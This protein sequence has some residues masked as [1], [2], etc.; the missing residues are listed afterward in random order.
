MNRR[1][2]PRIALTLLCLTLLPAVASA[3][4][5]R[6][7]SGSLAP[8]KQEKQ[9]NLEFDFTSMKVGS[10]PKN[11]V[12][13]AEFIARL[14]QNKPG[15]GDAWRREWVGSVP[16]YE[17]KFKELLNH[18]LES[19][20]RSLTFGAFKD[21][22][23]TLVLKTTTLVLGT[24]GFM[25]SSPFLSAD[26]IFVETAHRTNVSAVVVLEKMPGAGAFA[27]YMS[28]AFAKAGKDL[29]NLLRSKAR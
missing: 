19:G 28:E 21:A 6:V 29:G 5:I 20:H 10:K 17:N 25:P 4:A 7:Q 15:H 24:E 16:Q 23:H 1:A 14:N 11:V 18:Q 22:K 8:L 27:F 12:P 2:Q 3:G 26:A 9:I 13:E